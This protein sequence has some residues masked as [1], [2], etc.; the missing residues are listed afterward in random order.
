MSEKTLTKY[1]ICPICGEHNDPV[2]FECI[3]CNADIFSE[4]IVDEQTEL[5]ANQISEPLQQQLFRYCD[6]GEQNPPQARKCSACG[7]DISDVK[8]RPAVQ[9]QYYT[10]SS[11]DGQAALV[12]NEGETVI[13][14]EAT[15]SEYLTTK[16]FVSRKHAKLV[17]VNNELSI[18]NIST[19]NFTFINNELVSNKSVELHD[20][21]EIA[22][23]GKCIDG[24][25][26]DKAAYFIV[27]IGTCI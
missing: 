5:Q 12:I 26:Q 16:P 22:L 1:K 24:S 19:T 2:L 25:R 13:G 11:L 7:E 21:D 3:K 8:P 14:R 6:C 15:M 27:R 17:R 9:E 18:E 23:G 20:G 4:R 10:L